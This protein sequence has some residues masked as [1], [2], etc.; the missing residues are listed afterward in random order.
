MSS[1]LKGGGAKE[2]GYI[3]KNSGYFKD[4]FQKVLETVVYMHKI[5]DRS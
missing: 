3:M 1:Q 2:Q 5:T 4:D